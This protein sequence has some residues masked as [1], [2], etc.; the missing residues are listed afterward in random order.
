MYLK[1]FEN[2]K[3]R[4]SKYQFQHKWGDNP[5]SSRNSL[6]QNAGS[7]LGSQFSLAVV[8]YHQSLAE[9]VGLNVTDHKCL[10]ILQTVENPTPGMLA[11]MTGLSSAAVTTVI[12]RLEKA[13]YVERK[14]DDKDRR[15]TVLAVNREKVEK[16]LISLMVPFFSELGKLFS[17]YSPEEVKT[18]VD[19]L[20]KCTDI[21]K[22]ETKNLRGGAKKE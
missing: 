7:Q 11:S 5:L 8:L 14:R 6:S 4:F 17:Q 16:E 10:G 1:L 21:F 15:K 9:K 19:F 13:G 20:S 22:T 12:D 18:I 3:F 2:H